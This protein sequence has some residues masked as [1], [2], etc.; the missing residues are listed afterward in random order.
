[1]AVMT[2]KE[3][4][5]K[6][7]WLAEEVPTVYY[8]GSKWTEWNGTA[9]NM[10][11][12]VSVK[13]IL[14]GFNADR[15]KKKGGAVY[16]SNGVKDFT[17][18][19]ALD[20]CTEVSQD[21]MKLTPGEYLCMKGSSAN[22]TGIYLGDGK[23]YE[24]TSAWLKKCMISDIDTKGNRS[25]K[26]KKNIYKWTYHGKL[27][28]IDYTDQKP[29]WE[30]IEPKIMI[31]KKTYADKWDLSFSKWSEAKSVQVMQEH[32]AINIVAKF[33]HKLGG[34]YYIAEEDYKEGKFYGINS[35]DL[36]EL[37]E[38][39]GNDELPTNQTGEEDTFTEEVQ[40]ETNQK[41]QIPQVQEEV[42]ELDYYKDKERN[43]PL[44]HL[45]NC[46]V[47]LVKIIKSKFKK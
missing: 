9:W 27:K 31:V 24:C 46:I 25:Y 40:P 21:F 8:S 18:N 36:Q 16:A 19:G 37:T 5:K 11:C 13:S 38:E 39:T 14:W 22:H 43:N 41:D 44:L 34:L 17:C 4:I 45:I 33:K 2:S 26:G 1:M 32:E 28:Y 35:V 42:G 10:D 7:K 6:L 20:L 23:V 3:F 29:D 15:S 30:E 47:K 12:V